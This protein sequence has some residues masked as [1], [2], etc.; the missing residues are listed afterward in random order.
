[1]E[2]KLTTKIKYDAVFFTDMGSKFYHIRPL[3]AYRLASELRSHG[4][5][6]LVVDFLSEWVQD[7][8]EFFKLLKNIISDQTLFVG[9]SSTFFS[10]RDKEAIE[11]NSF[12]EFY[13]ADLSR[14]PAPAAEISIINTYIK[15]LNPN[16][17]ILHGGASSIPDKALKDGGVDYSVQGLADN[18]IIEIANSLKNGK[19]IKF[20]LKNNIKVIDYD[21]TASK[22]D[23]PNSETVFSPSDFLS[24]WEVLPM[25]TSRGCLF[26]CS[27][28]SF[29]LLGR[30]KNHPEYHKGVDI[31]A[32]EIKRNYETFGISSYMFSDDT[33]N[34]STEKLERIYQAIE[35]SGV[36][37]KFHCYLRID[38]IERFPEQIE[39]LKKMGLQSCFLGIETLNLTAAKAIGKS[40][41]PTRVKSTLIEMRKV[42]GG[43]VIIYGSFIAG[44]PHETESTIDE[45]MGWV[46][47][48][49]D[50]ID[51]FVLRS[52]FLSSS[53]LSESDISKNPGKY[54]YSLFNNG[55]WISNTGLSIYS[56]QIIAQ[57]WMEKAWQNNRLRVSGHELMA[58][59]G[60]GYTIDQLKTMTL[61]TLPFKELIVKHKQKF[62]QYQSQ[63]TEYVSK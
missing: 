61:N 47:D 14:W 10:Y 28:C 23:F 32:R 38:L 48:Q 2:L 3:G 15:K 34:E 9:Y 43:D 26:K 44:L 11:I 58:L 7:R 46:Y 53:T 1:M 12:E 24:S 54:G 18:V 13:S 63:L 40:S 4:Y 33:F 8:R 21:I 17:K 30:K 57:R 25:E 52:M 35:L 45:W 41:N 20:N 37:I 16:I 27:F 36:K 59:I 50:L 5:S 19:H 29:P 31:I 49:Q 56:A 22:F 55:A 39:L 62:K 6:V 60:L 42:W 51:G